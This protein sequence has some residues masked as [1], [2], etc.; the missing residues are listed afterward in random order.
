V[1]SCTGQFGL[2]L[3]H[4][5]SNGARDNSQERLA[6][7]VAWSISTTR[8]TI[9]GFAPYNPVLGET[10]HVSTS[11][12]GLNVRPRGAGLTPAARVMALH[13]TDAH[14]E[15][16]LVWCQSPTPVVPRRQRGGRGAGR[17]GASASPA[18]RDVSLKDVAIGEVFVLYDVQRAIG[19]LATPVASSE[20]LRARLPHSLHCAASG[21]RRAPPPCRHRAAS[22]LQRA[23]AP[24]V[25]RLTI[26]RR[27]P[28]PPHIVRVR[29]HVGSRAAGPC[30]RQ[31]TPPPQISMD[32]ASRFFKGEDDSIDCACGRKA[33]Q[34][35]V[36]QG[37]G[38]FRLLRNKLTR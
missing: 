13:A 33:Q 12:C 18:C 23:R 34:A 38:Y 4:D 11:G 29:A 22:D 2:C 7:V 26:C 14:G 37:E 20:E 31:P 16:R 9:F 6:V 27:R 24:R 8:P 15:V 21:C 35:R 28:R 5:V 30:R 25:H 1:E 19:D 10:Q 32:C 36:S 17:T 3:L